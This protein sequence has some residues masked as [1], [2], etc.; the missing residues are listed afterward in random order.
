MGDIA[1]GIGAPKTSLY[2]PGG[3]GSLK[4]LAKKGVIER[5]V[6][7]KQRGRGGKVTRVR[8]AYEKGFVKEYVERY[9]QK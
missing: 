9:L 4:E 8:I 7:F 1:K 3:R 6:A 2:S 5:R